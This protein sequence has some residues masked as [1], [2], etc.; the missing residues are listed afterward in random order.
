MSEHQIPIN[1]PLESFANPVEEQIE[2]EQYYND[3]WRKS[4]EDRQNRP[5]TIQEYEKWY[6]I[7]AF[8][9]MASELIYVKYVRDYHENYKGSRLLDNGNHHPTEP[10]KTLSM[11]TLQC[12]SEQ[13]ISKLAAMTNKYNTIKQENEHYK[14]LVDN[15]QN[16][17][18]YSPE[19]PRQPSQQCPSR[20]VKMKT[21]NEIVQLQSSTTPKKLYPVKAER[22]IKPPNTTHMKRMHS[23]RYTEVRSPSF[24]KSSE[25]IKNLDNPQAYIMSENNN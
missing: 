13:I 4:I 1:T 11:P 9:P 25:L 22:N 24:Y 5:L 19:R 6:E 8:C 20:P 23:F 17:Y 12:T 15:Y 7:A 2:H 10:E 21:T 3:L 18:A 16:N 14:S